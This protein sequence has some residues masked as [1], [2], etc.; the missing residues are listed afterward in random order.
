MSLFYR[1]P[2]KVLNNRRLHLWGRQQSKKREII[3][4]GPAIKKIL[5]HPHGM[6][7]GKLGTTELQA[8]EYSDRRIR[9]SWLLGATWRRQARR[10]FIDS[11]VFPEDR[12]EFEYFLNTYK[13]SIQQLDAVCLW[14]DQGSYLQA[15]ETAFVDDVCPRAASI[16]PAVF[17]PFSIYEQLEGVRLLIVSPFVR[18]MQAQVDRLPDV[19][20]GRS[21]AN[22]LKDMRQR[23]KFVRCPFFSYMEKSPY[24]SW[25]EGLDRITEAILRCQF[26][27]ALIGAGAWSLPLLANLKKEGRKGIHTGGATQLFFGIRG[28][29]WDVQKGYKIF[30]ANWIHPLPEDTPGGHLRKE[31]GC[32]W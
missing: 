28:K 27:L 19:F 22:S 16:K 11:G 30:N 29:R 18:T 8:L 1:Y 4:A 5:R 13:A 10:L 14:Q 25:R 21:W 31:E 9:S 7:Y 17:W 15:Y 24:T 23:C 12:N 32:Y 2:L 20:S 26:D 6:I 3:E